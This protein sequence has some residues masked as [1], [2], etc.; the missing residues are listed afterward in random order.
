MPDYL[1]FKYN[2]AGCQDWVQISGAIFTGFSSVRLGPKKILTGKMTEYVSESVT[3]LLRESIVLVSVPKLSI[4]H[5][6]KSGH[7]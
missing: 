7:K 4:V 5:N 1:S 2:L 6:E 3:Q